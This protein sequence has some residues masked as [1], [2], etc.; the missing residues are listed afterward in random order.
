MAWVRG[1]LIGGTVVAA[2]VGL[3]MVGYHDTVG[4]RVSTVIFGAIALG[5][6][7]GATIGAI[8]G[9]VRRRQVRIAAAPVRKLAARIQ[10]D[11]PNDVWERMLQDCETSVHQAGEAVALAPPGAATDW[12]VSLQG[13][14]EQELDG[15]RTIARLARMEF[16]HELVVVSSEAKQHMP[17]QQLIKAKADF[18]ASRQRVIDIVTQLVHRPD[19]DQVRTDLTML[20]QELP[21]LG[22]PDH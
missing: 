17:Y 1:A 2:L 19:L 7:P 22:D 5:G 21:V 3:G 6:L 11:R 15:V 8:I 13:R 14:M 10:D 12:L 18:E 20:E 9:A 4:D 16:P